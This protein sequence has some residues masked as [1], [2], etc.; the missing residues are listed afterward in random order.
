MIE[1]K[2]L[3]ATEPSVQAHLG[4]MQQVIQRMSANSSSC[5]AWCITLASAILVIVADKGKPDL[6]YLAYIPIGLFFI[7]DSYYLGLERS[8]RRSYN[9]FIAK[10]HRRELEPD[11]LYSVEPAGELLG[12][13]FYAIRSFSVWPFYLTLAV[14]AYLAKVLVL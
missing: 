10:L 13:V 1:Y 12:H 11:D 9:A 7:L 5:K 6:A 2:Q 3:D 14:M 8:F 4:I